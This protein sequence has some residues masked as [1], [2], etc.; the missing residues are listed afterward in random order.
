MIF[1]ITGKPDSEV[2]AKNLDTV[3]SLCHELGIPLAMDKNEGPSTEL[4]LLE[5]GSQKGSN[6]EG[7]REAIG[8][9]IFCLYSNST[10]LLLSEKAVVTKKH[11]FIILM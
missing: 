5:V 11:H 3:I 4:T 7:V 2:C 6:K 8:I 9:V 1:L 10:G